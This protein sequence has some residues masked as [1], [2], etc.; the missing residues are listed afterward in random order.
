[1][2]PC[3]AYTFS[4]SRAWRTYDRMAFSKP[5]HFAARSFLLNLTHQRRSFA[6]T[7]ATKN[8][9]MAH[10]SSI[11]PIANLSSIAGGIANGHIGKM[12]DTRRSVPKHR[13]SGSWLN[14]TNHW[15]L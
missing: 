10:L 7:V 4:T 6:Q 14:S 8:A 13:L 11:A 2:S 5:A 12:A 3:R 1:M 15:I 9:Q